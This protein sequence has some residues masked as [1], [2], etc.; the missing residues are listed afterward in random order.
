MAIKF[1][2]EPY[3]DDFETATSVDGLSPQEKY[4]KIL[5]RPGHAVQARELTQIQSILQHQVQAVGNHFFKEG[6]MVIPGH[7]SYEGKLDYIKL[8]T[9]SGIPQ[10][11]D[12]ASNAQGQAEYAAAYEAYFEDQVGNV[13]TGGTTGITA[14][15]VKVLDASGTD[16][17]T[18]YVKYLSSGSSG[19]TVFDD[20]ES[21]TSGSFTA[22]VDSSAATGF[23]S[24]AFV[25]RGIY[26]I[27]GHFVIVQDGSLILDKYD[28][29]P[30]Y[31][32]GLTITESIA[33][34][35]T[36]SSLND[37]ATGTPNY[38]AP[39]AH[40]YQIKTE[41]TKQAVEGTSIDN[42][43]LLI[44]VN[45]GILTQQ[46][47]KTDY[48][49][50]EETLARRTFDE[51]GNYTVRPFLVN[52]REHTDVNTPG[53]DTKLAVGVEPSKA[54]VRGFEIETLATTYVNLDKA[55]DSALFEA[56][57]VPMLVGNYVTIENVEG[58]PDI[59]TFEQME[60]HSSIGGA[61]GIVGY[62]RARSYV[63]AGSS[64]YRIYLFDIQMQSGYTFAEYAKSFK[65]ASTPEF[66][67]DIVLDSNSKAI[68]QEPT[69]NSMVFP[70]PFNRVKTCDSQPDGVADDFNYV[71]FCNRDV[72]TD[73]VQS[74]EATFSTV[75]S[76]ELF[77][78]FDDENWIMTVASGT[79][80]GDIV[81]LASG[82]VTIASN[83]E[84]V[85]IS[86]LGS[87]EG[88]NV[89]LI[90]GVKRSLDQKDKS[91]TTSGSDNIHLF[92][93]ANPSG[94]DQLGFADGYK[95]HAVYM[96]A[97]LST[98]ATVN[99]EDVSEY[100]DF[101]NGQR[102]N[103][104]DLCR[105]KLKSNT[106]F[107]PTGQLLVEYEYYTHGTG[108]FFTVDSYD[109]LEDSDGNEVTYED[110]PAFVSKTTGESIELR[111]AVDFRPRVSNAGNN[112]SG[113][114][115]QVS[116]CPE[117]LTTF[118]TDVQY[119]LNRIDKLYIDKEGEFGVVE[120]VPAINPELPEDPKD[121]MVLYNIFVPAYTIGPEEVVIDMI[122]N[123]R[124]T[125]RDIG[126][127]EKRIN[128]LE[129]YTSLSLLEQEAADKQIV[130]TATQVQRLK[131]GFL[132]DSFTSHNVGNVSSPEYRCS[133]D[134][135]NHLLRPAFSEDNVRLLYNSSL[136]SNIQKT[137]DLITL[138]YSS[139]SLFYQ[140]QAS[141]TI[142]VNPF[143]VFSWGGSLELSPTSDEWKDTTRR[144]N[145]IVDQEG[146][147][148]AMLATIRETDALGTVW[149]EWQ[150]NWTGV[151]NTS[152]SKSFGNGSRRGWS[153]R[154]ETTTTTTTRQGQ[155]RTGIETY[156]VPD[157]ILT[158][159]GDRV[160]EVNFAP[161]IRSRIVNFRATRLKPNT[162][163]FAFFDD[164][165]VAP[166]VR[167][168]SSFTE[169]TAGDQLT[170]NG[171]NTYTAHPDGSTSLTT[172]ANGELIGSFFIPNNDSTTFQTGNRVFRLSD[173]SADNEVNVTTFAEARYNAKGLIET[174]ENV[175]ISTRVPRIERREVSRNRI[176][177][178][179]RSST[180]GSWYD[181]LAQS[182]MVDLEGGA[183]ITSID[184]FFH[185]KAAGV[186]VTVQIREMNQGLPTQT[187]LP[188][189]EVTLNPADVNVVD[190]TSNNPDPNQVTTFTFP[191]PVFL[192]E[193]QEYCFVVM[194]N[195]NEYECWFAEIGEDNYITGERIS[196][197]PYAG[198]L[199][200][201]QNASTWSPD[202]NKDLKFR[203]NRA[204]F[205]I[206]NPGTIVLNNGSVQERQLIKNPFKTTNGSS[207]VRVYHPNHHF[208]EETNSI[209]SFVTIAG[210]TDVN[211]ILAA[212]MNGTHQVQQVEMDSYVIDVGSNATGTGIDGGTAV[213]ATEN[214]GFNTFYPYVQQVNLP[215]TNSTWGVRTCTGM[216]LGA[217]TPTPYVVDASYEPV[218]VNEN[219]TADASK[220]IASD[221]NEQQG[222]S[223][224]LRGTLTS[225]KDNISPVID[226][227]RASVFTIANRIDNPVGDNPDY[228]GSSTDE[229]VDSLGNTFPAVSGN[230]NTAPTGYNYVEDFAQE[231]Q[232]DTGS[233]AGKYVT[234]AVTL[235]EAA[236]GLRLFI[237]VNKPSRTQVDLM[238]KAVQTE[239]E[240]ATT[241]WTYAAPTETIPF[242]DDGSYREVEWVI[243]P[244]GNFNVFQLKV[245]LRSRNASAVP[246][247]KALRAIALVP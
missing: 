53:D 127:L 102:D 75:G 56:A 51:S 154:V 120:G 159:L 205:D 139:V 195:T 160:V 6:S 8:D 179:S 28:V 146:V 203:I 49:V 69:R 247:I 58:I 134:R 21:L 19:E 54:Y 57:S 201:S 217:T 35:A 36:D 2:V 150:T 72:G 10:S 64:E 3:Y 234:K 128:S 180:S 82:N 45:E 41:L 108:D 15:V 119:Y 70:L 218:I 33:D 190:L 55:R 143:D 124:Y 187:I 184:L 229:F 63:Y 86:G 208:Y 104:Y 169:Y 68:I 59:A 223:F 232:T 176:I 109:G 132:V 161:Y 137:G 181:P 101:D 166:W 172:N 246:S 210:A 100:Y 138:P 185:K 175:T 202:Q 219:Y 135:P 197:Q 200:K 245:V 243:D 24:A 212:T 32:V 235:G 61:G 27:K 31:D 170:V 213:T 78:P 153:N 155:S 130:D 192:Q 81:S 29:N 96:S 149:G 85:V 87:Y 105:L 144:P 206:D 178:S 188:F 199:F 46:V 123:K 80:N 34:S 107:S 165:A 157:T 126:K 7:V 177:S 110:I 79:N 38:A 131:S 191:S 111:S 239:E 204:D 224:Y 186:P 167:E 66:I 194:A 16:P 99:D 43:L 83:S 12:Y 182:F 1:N 162:E 4:N 207:E 9:L 39:G 173:D 241:D 52:V 237:D 145:V 220:V 44:R 227:E 23:G 221:D 230:P 89:R 116:V 95:L 129:Y 18:M 225:T 156:V 236:D 196:K 92:S 133:I 88:E 136:S 73:N 122:D 30:S 74:G 117:P 60:I 214:Q 76:S 13:Y 226:L 147:Y 62:A 67:A 106:A 158:N 113:T 84:S 222:K 22:T 5:F 20:G 37:N 233:A 94:D 103:F 142:N 97:D 216:S 114:G 77:E 141:S 25:D 151:S 231:T 215:G 228:P 50:I 98:A 93:I 183:F 26:Y 115:A 238:Y 174:K 209:G 189:A 42:F 91:L 244:T 211:G 240:I 48:S 242:S 140:Q 47:R 40:R 125:M 171:K 14:R 90:A 17:I 168:E 71:Y 65:L 193:N 112:F 198:V 118:T 148:D 121:A 152:T 163:V 164:V 11:G